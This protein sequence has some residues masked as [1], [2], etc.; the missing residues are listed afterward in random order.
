[1]PTIDLTDAELAAVAA[2]I[3]GFIEDDRFPHAHLEAHLAG[4]GEHD[5]ALGLDRLAERDAA[6]AGNEECEPS[7]RSS[8]GRWRG[9]SVNFP[10]SGLTFAGNDKELAHSSKHQLLAPAT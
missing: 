7:R 8:S 10:G 5:R 9:N 2:V 1:M 4:L 6:D 3:R